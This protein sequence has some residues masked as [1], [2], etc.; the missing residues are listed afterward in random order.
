MR[1][2]ALIGTTAIAA[3]VLSAAPI[4]VNWSAGKNLSVSQDKA[5]AVYGR[6]ATPASVA[7]VHRRHV[8]REV[9]RHYY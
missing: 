7:G 5:F 2:L 9:R 6:P 3:A 4:S 1:R 8:R